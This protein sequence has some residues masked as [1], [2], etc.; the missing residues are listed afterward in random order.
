MIL[1]VFSFGFIIRFIIGF[2]YFIFVLFFLIFLMLTD[3]FAWCN[4][5]ELMNWWIDELMNLNQSIYHEI[6]KLIN[7]W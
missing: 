2:I 3:C 4:I 6:I 5:D 1:F 7:S